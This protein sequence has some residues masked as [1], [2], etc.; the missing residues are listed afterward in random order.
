[1][2]ENIPAAEHHESAAFHDEAAARHHR[3]A[4]RHFTSGK[5]HA[6]GAHQAWMAHGH[7]MQAI[8]HD[9]AANAGG[10]GSV[11]DA[12]EVRP[13]AVAGYARIPVAVAGATLT[14]LTRAEHHTAAADHHQ[15]AAR[16]HLEAARHMKTGGP[17]G[18]AAKAAHRH[19]QLSIFH[20][21]EAAKHH[22][23]HNRRSG[24]T[25]EL[26]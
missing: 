21:G 12:I 10:S 7:A 20:G 19:A 24:P 4:A 18:D 26:A 16:Y 13:E 14:E 3:E 9:N 22:V 25:A 5:D 23:E 1:M 15:K 11:E 2:N 8:S 6:H 17:A